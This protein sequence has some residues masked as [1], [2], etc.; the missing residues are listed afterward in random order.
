MYS[1]NAPYV[2]PLQAGQTVYLCRC[3]KTANPP[4]CDGAHETHNTGLS[5]QAHTAEK[6]GEIYAC[7]CGRS[8]SM[9][10][11]DGTHAK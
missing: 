8:G 6:D 10:F 11:C 2:V 5:P 7:G 9:P 4:F 1:K 3:G